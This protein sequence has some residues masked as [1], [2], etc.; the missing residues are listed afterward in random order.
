MEKYL[1][2]LVKRHVRV[3]IPDFG[4]LIVS[5]GNEKVSIIF[6]AFLKFNDGLLIGHISNEEGIDTAVAAKKVEE[7]VNKIKDTLAQGNKFV[8]KGIGVFS[9]E[10]SGSIKFS[11]NEN[12]KQIAS[13]PEIKSK[14]NDSSLETNDDLLDLGT[15]DDST[16]VEAESKVKTEPVKPIEIKPIAT[17]VKPVETKPTAAPAKPVETKPKVEPA[18][19]VENKPKIENKKPE[20]APK[21][22]KPPKPPK[23]KKSNDGK[24]F[25]VWIPIVIVVALLLMAA[26]YYFFVDAKTF[27][28]FSHDCTFDFFKKKQVEVVIPE[29]VEEE[30]VVEV[31]EVVEPVKEEPVTTFPQH[32]IIIGCFK[33]QSQADKL[34]D[35]L[36]SKGYN[37]AKIFER[38][39]YLMVS[40]ECYSSAN[41][42][43]ERQEELLDE[44]KV[45][46]WVLSLKK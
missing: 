31:V 28:L 34:L 3:I 5:S 26:A 4:A 27:N 24:K 15:S 37:Q 17:P 38:D 23:T 45:D 36:R 30:P 8:I 32:H 22:P 16:A 10:V 12:E 25:P 6:N 44:L 19:P 40:V 1:L 35:N 13:E 2:D 43:L 14:K 46:N 42:A 29:V 9:K 20:K 39:G 41:K 18:K 33:E 7:F 11:Q 21:P